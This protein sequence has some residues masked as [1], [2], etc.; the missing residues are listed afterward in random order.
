MA[1]VVVEIEIPYSA[2]D[3]MRISNK[4]EKDMEEEF[5]EIVR[6]LAVFED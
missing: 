3:M 1:R 6:V 5:G 4:L 2:E